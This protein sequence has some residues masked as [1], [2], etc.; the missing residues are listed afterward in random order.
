MRW[1]ILD[2]CNG[3]HWAGKAR[4]VSIPGYRL[5]WGRMVIVFFCVERE[6]DILVGAIQSM[7]SLLCVL[8]PVCAREC[9]VV[10]RW[11]E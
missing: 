10:R 7:T 9:E 5:G 6:L 1:D 8:R 2:G 11:R 3:R 4:R